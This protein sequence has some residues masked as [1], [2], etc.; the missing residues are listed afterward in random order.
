MSRREKV[1]LVLTLSMPAILGQLS[2]IVM[3]YIDTMMV[4]QLGANATASIGLVSTTCWLFGGLSASLGAGFSVL[5]AQHIGAK[6]YGKARNV[7][8]QALLVCLSLGVLISLFCVSI[9]SWWPRALG[10]T[11]EVAA[12]S[13][14][15]FLVWA[16]TVPVMQLLFLS[17]SMLR[18]SGNMKTPMQLGVMMAALDVVFNLLLIP[19]WGVVGAALATSV[20]GTITAACSFGYLI[21]RS[22]ELAL[23]GEAR[24]VRGGK[25]CAEGRRDWLRPCR[26]SFD[27]P[28][29]RR[30]LHIGLPMAVEHVVFCGAQIVSTLIVAPLGPV[31]IAANTIGVVVESLCY[32][33]GYG[34]GDAA[35]TLIGQSYGARRGDLIRSFSILTVLMGVGVMTLLGVVMYVAAPELMIMMTPDPAV[36]A[37]GTMALRIEAFAEPMYAASIVVYGVFMGLGDTLVPCIMNLGSIWLVRIPLAALLA[38]TMGLKGVWL[39]M[40][41]ELTVRGII[42]LLRLRFK[43]IKVKK[44]ES[45]VTLESPDN[46]ESPEHP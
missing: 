1:S 14:K 18:S 33:P 4:G 21:T 10:G 34:I 44:A 12:L 46:P 27:V 31:A 3:Q 39:A 6:E 25:E 38:R 17:N 8:R 36:Q 28:I 7:L 30:S 26:L 45:P 24:R 35:T 16:L 23:W 19:V 40:A 41:I 9:H 43:K 42:F 5:V 29:I 13:S 32:M 22:P 37:D 2:T 11:P 15:Y 20:A